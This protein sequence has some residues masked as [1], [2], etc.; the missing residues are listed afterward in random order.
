MTKTK[1]RRNR[2]NKIKK[3]RKNQNGGE[4]PKQNDETLT[5]ENPVTIENQEIIDTP[6]I[7]NVVPEMPIV[8]A[9]SIDEHQKELFE[10]IKGINNPEISNLIEKL[11]DKA[12]SEDELIQLEKIINKINNT[13]EQQVVPTVEEPV[14]IEENKPGSEN[15]EQKCFSYVGDTEFILKIPLV[16]KDKILKLLNDDECSY[17]VTDAKGNVIN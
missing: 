7:E 11:Q 3:S 17:T 14:Q 12:L 16:Y 5:T 4:E 10:K 9:K 2:N 1:T 6:E 8:E 15:I 13:S